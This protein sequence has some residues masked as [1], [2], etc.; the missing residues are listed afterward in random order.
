MNAADFQSALS[1][2]RASVSAKELQAFE[3]WNQLY[4]SFQ[5]EPARAKA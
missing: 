5:K 2:A 3:E 4:G 1:Q